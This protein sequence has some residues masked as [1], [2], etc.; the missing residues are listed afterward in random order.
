MNVLQN[1][2]RVHFCFLIVIVVSG[3]QGTQLNPTET[4][5]KGGNI[6][7]VFQPLSP[8]PNNQGLAAING[9]QFITSLTAEALYRAERAAK[10][11]DVIAALSIEA[12]LG[13]NKAFDPREFLEFDSHCLHPPFI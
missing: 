3:P 6:N 4:K 2:H 11:A 7:Y 12:L 10:Q 8:L 1:Y 13:T 5:S 9:T